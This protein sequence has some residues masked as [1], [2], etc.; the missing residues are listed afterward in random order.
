MYCVELKDSVVRARRDEAIAGLPR[1]EW[2]EARRQEGIARRAFEEKHRLGA[3]HWVS[4]KKQ[5]VDLRNALPREVKEQ[6]WLCEFCY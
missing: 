2:K 6:T 5:A 4:T 3:R 1:E